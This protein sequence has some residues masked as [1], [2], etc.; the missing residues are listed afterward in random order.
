MTKE[1]IEALDKIPFKELYKYFQKRKAD[2]SVELK[3]TKSQRH[4]CKN[5]AFRIWGKV[6]K[7]GSIH[8]GSTW[9]C[10]KKPK[11]IKSGYAD[12]LPAYMKAY[13]VC[14]MTSIKPC[15]MFL[16]KDSEEG[17][18]VVEHNRQI[19]DTSYESE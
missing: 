16:H 12:D 14:R 6:Y 10:I 5:C 7:N 3:E 9:V 19:T 15:K 1:E 11:K 13:K 2:H 18:K 4:I 17:K 8:G